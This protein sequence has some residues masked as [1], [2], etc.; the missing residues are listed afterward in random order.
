MIADTAV[1]GNVYIGH[2]E[3]IIT[4]L[5]HTLAACLGTPVDGCALADVDTVTD[6]NIGD[7]TVKLEVLRYSS[8]DSSREN[9]AVLAHP[10]VRKDGCVRID[11]ASVTYFNIVVNI[12]V[13]SNFDVVSELGSGMHCCK[14]MDFVHN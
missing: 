1:V 3:C 6:F 13:W 7:F 14:W 9:I 5:C 8:D 10:G 4:H 2:D 11:M 12:C